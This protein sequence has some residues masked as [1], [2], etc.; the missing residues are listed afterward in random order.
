MRM[1]EPD[2]THADSGQAAM[3]AACIAQTR[4]D[5]VDAILSVSHRICN[6]CFDVLSIS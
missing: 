4:D 1:L 2:V 3:A 6:G 5:S